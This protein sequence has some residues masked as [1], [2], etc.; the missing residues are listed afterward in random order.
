M[1][2]ILS[3]IDTQRF[4]LPIARCADLTI[5]ELAPAL[6]WCHA[7]D[8]RMLIARCATRNLAVA[9][10]MESAGFRLMDTLLEYRRP[11]TGSLGSADS[12]IW[13]A[14]P[15]DADEVAAIAA[16]AFHSY[17]GHYHADSRLDR[18]DCDAVYTS[19]A[20]SA[21]QS[22]S[23]QNILLVSGAPGSLTGFASFRRNADQGELSLYAVHPQHQGSGLGRRLVETGL[24]WT[25]EHGALEA[26]SW[27]Q[28]TNLAS[29]RL[30]VKLGFSP[31]E[32][33]YTFHKW[34]T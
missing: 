8:V 14:G 16:L 25:A 31:A 20:R 13:A 26:V 33:F 10:A 3:A 22:P 21:C 27:T 29:Q 32:S 12:S 34:F 19:W 11:L 1:M 5:G 4:R 6:E 7:Q 17:N 24:Q 23:P 9:Q 30:W 28:I 18:A 15:D 2:P